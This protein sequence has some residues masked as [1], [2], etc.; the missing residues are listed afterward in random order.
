[1]KTENVLLCMGT[2][3]EIIKMAPVYYA[4]KEQ[5]METLL[6]H[7]GQHKDMADPMYQFFNIVPDFS[8]PLP[9]TSDALY[10]LSALLLEKLGAA[11]SAIKPSAVL[12]HGDTSSAA[13]AALAAFYQKI[14]VGHVEAGLRSHRDYDPFPEEKNREIIGRLAHWHFAP[15]AQARH[16]LLRENIP[17]ARI[18]MVGNT[19]VDAVRLAD[20]TFLD[21]ARHAHELASGP[22]KTLAA[23]LVGRRLLFITAH[24]RENLGQ[25]LRSITAS[26]RELLETDPDIVV[27]WPVHS[28]PK[29]RA[30]VD[31]VFDDL[32]PEIAERLFLTRP[33]SYPTTLSMLKQAWLALT[34]SGGIQEEAACMNLPVL[35]L[36]E[37]TERPELVESGGGILVGT[38][39]RAIVG[40]ARRLAQDPAA[41]QAMR[42]APNPFGD[43][44]AATRI[45]NILSRSEHAT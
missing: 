14:P 26:V 8:L 19:I 31:E 21:S 10:H 37:T 5:G 25:P 16:N 32:P 38:S 20:S 18:H 3:P 2:R 39:Q 1:M 35:I 36:R 15:T 6:L 11:F 23:R 41:H 33:L 7:T 17:D 40:E 43:G 42:N 24:R 44:Y 27:L 13:M 29:V 12:V 22:L 28:N 30:T 9:R 4:L 45:H 34:D